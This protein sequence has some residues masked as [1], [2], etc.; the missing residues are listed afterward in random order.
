MELLYDI[1]IDAYC[2]HYS[3][4]YEGHSFIKIL[5]RRKALLEYIDILDDVNS[6]Q[7]HIKWKV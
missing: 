4:R 5:H 7:Q 6:F 1:N 2:W 3:K